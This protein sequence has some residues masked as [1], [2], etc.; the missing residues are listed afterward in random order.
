MPVGLH[1]QIIQQMCKDQLLLLGVFRKGRSRV[2]LEDNGIYFT[3]VEFQPSGFSAGTYLNVGLHPLWTV[4]MQDHLTFI[5]EKGSRLCP[6]LPFE[7]EAQFRAG[8][9][10][11]FAKAKEQILY[12]RQY[13]DPAVLRE[14][15]GRRVKRIGTIPD[16]DIWEQYLE[17]S[18][19]ELSQR[20]NTAREFW[21]RQSSMRN[22]RSELY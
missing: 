21:R 1:D 9:A 20:V 13:R 4:P 18:A 11:Y 22:M 16:R 14:Y 17:L 5:S 2:Y 19:S 10:P 12:Y 3:V 6:F 15:A 8:L 7:T